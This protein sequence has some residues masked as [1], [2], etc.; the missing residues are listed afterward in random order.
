[1]PIIAHS[2]F[3]RAPLSLQMA[4][5]ELVRL[6]AFEDVFEAASFCT[7]FGFYCE[8]ADA[9]GGGRVYLERQAFVT[10]EF[11]LAPRR[12][13]GLI[14]SKQGARSAGE[15]RRRGGLGWERRGGEV[16]GREGRGS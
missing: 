16:R 11:G 12:A 9:A 7:H 15:V 10:P 1:M 8:D 6:L 14:E 2:V 5:S 4:L 3:S 13:R